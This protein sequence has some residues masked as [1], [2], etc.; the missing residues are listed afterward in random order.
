[1]TNDWVARLLLRMA[2][3]AEAVD[4][5]DSEA[6]GALVAAAIDLRPVIP[7]LD[8]EVGAADSKLKVALLIGDERYPAQSATEL[9]EV[10]AAQMRG[11][12]TPSN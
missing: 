2:D 7:D 5:G 4:A 8:I 9:V 1:M 3:L 10:L 12:G 11:L 6:L